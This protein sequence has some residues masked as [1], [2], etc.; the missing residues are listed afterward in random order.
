VNQKSR[1]QDLDQDLKD[2]IRD[3]VPRLLGCAGYG[4]DDR[5]EIEQELT[6]RFM[7]KLEA[8]PA[9]ADFPGRT[10]KQVISNITRDSRAQKR[11]GGRQA[12]L[13]QPR[14]SQSGMVSTPADHLTEDRRRH[15]SIVDADQAVDL[16]EAMTRLPADLRVV[17]ERLWEGWSVTEIA[18][19]LG[20]SR[21]TVY[22]RVGR[23]VETLR[24]EFFPES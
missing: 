19:D 5:E 6:V 24:E 10:L 12:S 13:N 7:L 14:R 20:I 15:R 17:V 18:R 9:C 3:K 22:R 2:L 11:D 4:P 23:A 21:A 16:R 8:S 1:P